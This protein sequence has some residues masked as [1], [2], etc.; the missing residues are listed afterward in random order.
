MS[1]EESIGRY[2]N[3]EINRRGR[4]VSVN[5]SVL[6]YIVNLPFEIFYRENKYTYVTMLIF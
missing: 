5:Y 2:I 4:G 6:Y 1:D 3:F